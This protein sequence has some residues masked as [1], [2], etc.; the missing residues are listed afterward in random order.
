MSTM[1]GHEPECTKVETPSVELD[2]AGR[3]RDLGEGFTVRRVLPSPLRRLVGPFVFF[4]HMGPVHLPSGGGMDVRPHPHIGVATVTYLFEGE[5]LHRDSVGSEQ[6]ITPGGVNWMTAGRGIVHSERSPAAGRKSGASIHGL[7][8]WIALPKEHEE[9]APSF[10]HHDERDI[11][12][13]ERPGARMRVVAGSAYETRSPV[14]VHSDMFYVDVELEAGATLDLPEEYAERAMYV[15]DGTVVADGTRRDPGTMSV[16]R[17]GAPARVSAAQRARVMLLGGAPLEGERHI[18]WNFVSSRKER[19]EEAKTAWEE[20][21]F[22]SVPGDDQ[23]Y[24]PLPDYGR[25]R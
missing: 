24:I 4:D 11:P 25:P 15:V 21:R 3:A 2:I 18:F 10:E 13:V 19:I 1:P 17:S 8:L 22:A 23:E 14:H 12:R 16:F 6:L 5:I 7:Q 9:I 20:R